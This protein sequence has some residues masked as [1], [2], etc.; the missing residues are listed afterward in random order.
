MA[1]D[2]NI[3][4]KL[5]IEKIKKE[6]SIIL[7]TMDVSFKIEPNY[8]NNSN[9]TIRILV[10][11]RIFGHGYI[12]HK[13]TEKD[14]L[15]DCYSRLHDYNSDSPKWNIWS[16]KCTSLEECYNWQVEQIIEFITI[17]S[18][19]KFNEIDILFTDMPGELD[20]NGFRKYEMILSIRGMQII[21]KRIDIYNY[22]FKLAEEIINELKGRNWS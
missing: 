13:S 5:F 8:E 14:F 20:S 4:Q 9:T 22:N 18:D 19:I 12:D 16:L 7:K 1:I 11:E 3:L 17:S 10:F 6:E 21:A 15:A 2:F